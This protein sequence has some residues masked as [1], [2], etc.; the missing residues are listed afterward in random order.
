MQFFEKRGGCGRKPTNK[1]TFPHVFHA[2]IRGDSLSMQ[3]VSVLLVPFLVT[4]LRHELLFARS[5]C[6]AT[7][8]LPKRP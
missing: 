1:C 7:I 2:V 4:H 6:V 3:F 8:P 5:E